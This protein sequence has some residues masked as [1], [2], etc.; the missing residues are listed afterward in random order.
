MLPM[1]IE[2]RA[3][4]PGPTEPLPPFNA[5]PLQLSD[6]EVGFAWYTSP[7]T[8]VTQALPAHATARVSDVLSDWVD[9]VLQRHS[10]EIH[11]CGGL[12]GVHDWRRFRS[13]DSEARRRWMQRI[14][15]RP[16][17]YLRKG[18]IIIADNPLIKMAVAGANM[19][20]AMASGGGSQFE[21]ATNALQVLQK[22]DVRRPSP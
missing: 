15:R 8:L 22:Y 10:E 7:A 11:R 5:W 16:K 20:V 2:Q 9:L 17:G 3:P 1:S 13:Y 19:I 6:P 21:I 4:S 14:Q 12:L 18:V